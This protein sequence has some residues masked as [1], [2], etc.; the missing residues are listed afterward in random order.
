MLKSK[1]TGS[2]NLSQGNITNNSN[3]KLTSKSKDTSKSREESKYDIRNIASIDWFKLVEKLNMLKISMNDKGLLEQSIIYYD[4]QK[5]LRMFD[6]KKYFPGLFFDVY[7]SVGNKAH[8]IY[9]FIDRNKDTVEWHLTEQLYQF[10]KKRF[11]NMPITASNTQEHETQDFP[12]F[13]DKLVQINESNKTLINDLHYMKD[14]RDINSNTDTEQV[15]LD[16]IIDNLDD[17]LE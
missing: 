16:S 17:L 1:V 14:G 10:D 12:M 8:D 13:E 4:I 15:E 9:K 6:P 3:E 5:E 11:L 7:A 2:E